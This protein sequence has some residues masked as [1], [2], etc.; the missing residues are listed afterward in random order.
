MFD[1][2]FLYHDG[3]IDNNFIRTVAVYI[4]KK[5]QNQNGYQFGYAGAA[6]VILFVFTAALGSIT[7][8]LNR[9]KDEVLKRKQRKML[10]KQAKAKKSQFGGLG[11]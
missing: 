11:I 2:P 8:I 10:I 4:L 9:D 6:S 7:F 5:Y 1:I 3:T